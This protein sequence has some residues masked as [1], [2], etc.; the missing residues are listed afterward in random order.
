MEIKKYKIGYGVH[1]D[2]KGDW[3][4]LSCHEEVVGYL[5]KDISDLKQENKILKDKIE[6]LSQRIK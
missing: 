5:Y 6:K 1:E 4:K 3:V 2:K